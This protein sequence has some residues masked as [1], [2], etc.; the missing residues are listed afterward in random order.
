MEETLELQHILEI[1]TKYTFK[2]NS[3]E[4]LTSII[5]R[6]EIITVYQQ[7]ALYL[8]QQ[9]QFNYAI[10]TWELGV[11]SVESCK[12]IEEKFELFKQY[13]LALNSYKGDYKNTIC[14]LSEAQNILKKEDAKSEDSLE[15]LF[16]IS[17]AYLNLNNLYKY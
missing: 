17:K 13:G 14:Y 8:Y 2:I 6:N 9:E 5:P 12:S 7:L 3:K 4:A 10:K 11:E 1:S 16:G 15:I